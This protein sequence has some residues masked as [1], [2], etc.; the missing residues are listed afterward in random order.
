MNPIVRYML[1][2]DDIRVDAD[3]PEC[4]HVDC[5]LS[6]IVSLELPPFPFVR[7]MLCIYLALTE[8]HGNGVAQ[9]RVLYSDG[10][11]EAPLFGSPEHR[12]DFTGHSPLEVLGI[13]FR[14][15]ECTF[16]ESGRYTV[17]FWYNG[18]VVEE[19]PLRLKEGS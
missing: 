18:Q 2:C 11:H 8:C 16:P 14:I 15:E 10:E 17:Q 13:V 9:I 7:E 19:R 1:L 5:L 12:L 3:N 6:N 4:V